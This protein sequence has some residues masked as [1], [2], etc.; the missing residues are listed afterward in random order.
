[1]PPPP[2]LPLAP[3]AP[4]APQGDGVK[5]R[6]ARGVLSRRTFALVIPLCTLS[7][8]K[9][10]RSCPSLGNSEPHQTLRMVARLAVA[11]QARSGS[12]CESAPAVPAKLPTEGSG[13]MMA[14]Q[15]D[16]HGYETGSERA[17]WRCLKYAR[18]L[19]QDYQFGYE[20]G[21]G[22]VGP[23]EGLPDPG[24]DGF[25]VWAR[26]DL[27]GDGTT[28]LY[29]IVGRRDAASGAISIGKLSCVRPGQ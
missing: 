4:A 12:L 29:T 26:G 22:Y 11:A 23:R 18:H 3:A 8:C 20:S 24:P 28:S 7:G 1:M 6:Y 14:D 16:G 13:K 15:A 5:V 19:P 21:S 9:T 27:D 25:E 10:E 17:G 2:E